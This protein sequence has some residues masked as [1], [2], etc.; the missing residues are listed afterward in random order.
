MNVHK[1]VT[2]VGHKRTWAI[3]VIVII[4]QES[5]GLLTTIMQSEPAQVKRIGYPVMLK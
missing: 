4:V 5:P 1:N 3:S 2:I